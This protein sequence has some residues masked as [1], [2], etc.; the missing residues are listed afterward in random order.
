MSIAIQTHPTI[1]AAKDLRSAA[2]AG[3]DQ[4]RAGFF[5]TIDARVAEGPARTTNSTTR[6]RSTRSP[7]SPQSDFLYRTD[8]SVTITQSLFDGALT[9]SSTDAARATFD[10]AGFQLLDAGEALGLRAVSS[11][12]DVIRSRGLLELARNNL[13]QHQDIVDRIL[14]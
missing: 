4:A 5:P 9:R 11:F 14:F 10:A 13:V 12:L 6:A 7:N 8:S 3:V 1:A 2:D